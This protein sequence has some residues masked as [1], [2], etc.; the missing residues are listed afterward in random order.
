[1][2]TVM[3]LGP[4]YKQDR[5]TQTLHEPFSVHSRSGKFLRSILDEMKRGVDF[6][7]ANVIPRAVFD[8]GG[9]ERNP[10]GTELLDYVISD[11][12]WK[13]ANAD[14]IIGLSSDVRKAFELLEKRL[15]PI[16]QPVNIA[17][18]QFL[19]LEHPSFVMRQP[20]ER[21]AEYAERLRSGIR[22]S[23]AGL[24]AL[25]LRPTAKRVG[26]HSLRGQT[27]AA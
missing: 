23:L 22:S 17:G 14:V 9:K 24:A 13:R 15:L 20:A 8:A 1:M 19:F 7:F 10:K 2:T 25:P 11:E 3:F 16:S 21:R 4:C 6:G 18:R 27:L 12:F 5:K 26:T